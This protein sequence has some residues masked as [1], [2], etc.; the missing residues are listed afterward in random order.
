MRRAAS[1]GSRGDEPATD[2]D[3]GEGRRRRP[4]PAT[5]EEEERRARDSERS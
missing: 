4:R 5:R 1:E 2:G 3:G